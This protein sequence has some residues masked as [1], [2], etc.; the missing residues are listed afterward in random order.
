[1]RG[2]VARPAACRYRVLVAERQRGAPA[3]TD[4]PASEDPEE[5]SGYPGE[6]FGLPQ[7]GRGSVSGMG[8]RLA[9]LIIDWVLCEFIAL[10]AFHDQYLTLAVYAVEVYVLTALTGFTIGKRLL[11]IRV[12]RVDGKPV[13][14]VWSLLR[15]V[16]FL[17]VIPPLVEDGDRR[18]LHDRAA[19][20]IVIRV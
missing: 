3:V 7:A 9:A 2:V 13:G 1:M 8:R 15:T 20:T 5:Q 19:N 16:L 11:G 10:A 6:R 17:C 4:A 14:L 18:G 12:A